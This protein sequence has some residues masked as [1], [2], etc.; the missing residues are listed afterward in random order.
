MVKFTANQL[1]I[2]SNIKDLS[3]FTIFLDIIIIFSH[4]YQSFLVV[5]EVYLI[6]AI[7]SLVHDAFY[8]TDLFSRVKGVTFINFIDIS[9]CVSLSITKF[10]SKCK[11]F[12]PH[13]LCNLQLAEFLQTFVLN[14]FHLWNTHTACHPL[15]SILWNNSFA[16]L[17]SLKNLLCNNSF[18]LLLID[19]R[20]QA[21]SCR[22][23][24]DST[25]RHSVIKSLLSLCYIV[26]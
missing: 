22:F 21:E 20:L 19:K 1:L 17:D 26:Y 16:P 18:F 6:D 25:S 11:S 24:C 8:P 15:N 13:Y 7:F 2:V 10:K 14:L 23:V 12:T 4:C 5:E 9:S 3:S